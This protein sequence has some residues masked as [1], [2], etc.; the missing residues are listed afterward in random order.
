M[1]TIYYLAS[2]LLITSFS[3]NSKSEF[4]VPVIY[5][6]AIFDEDIPENKYRAWQTI[7]VEP[8]RYAISE[9]NLNIYKINRENEIIASVGGS[10]FGPSEFQ[11]ISKLQFD[12][13]YLYVFDNI[14]RKVV[15]L[16]GQ[17]NL[18]REFVIKESLVD[19]DFT[20]PG[21]AYA[22]HLTMD[23][24]SLLRYDKNTFDLPDYLHIETTRRPEFGIAHLTVYENTILINHI[25][26]N[27]STLFD[28]ATGTTSRIIYEHLDTRPPLRRVG[29]L[30][31]PEGPVWL[32]GELFDDQII[33]L[34]KEDERFTVILTN[35]RGKP[36]LK[37]KLKEDLDTAVIRPSGIFGSRDES[38]YYYPLERLTG[39]ETS[40]PI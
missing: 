24:W 13:N 6:S 34:S 3:C 38:I 1:K 21:I 11:R 35:V 37:I 4:E 40:K 15:V 25:F 7:S 23:G 12:G 10:G 39:N 19:I 26:T 14:A 32:G 17:L 29:T 28:K 27:R 31:V 18:V 30:E 36:T 8:Y 2:F 5:V 20:I 9:S 16:D 22:T 33:Q